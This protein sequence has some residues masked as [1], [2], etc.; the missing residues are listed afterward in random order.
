ML[1]EKTDRI[2]ELLDAWL[3]GTIDQQGTVELNEFVDRH[4]NAT[5]LL[6]E[7]DRPAREYLGVLA[8]HD[9]EKGWKTL[10]KRLFGSI[11]GGINRWRIASWKIAAGVILLIGGAIMAYLLS[12]SDQQVPVIAD[13]NQH[14]VPS[15]TEYPLLI[16]TDG[17]KIKLDSLPEIASVNDAGME[18]KA[19]KDSG[20]SYLGVKG[21]MVASGLNTLYVPY[22]KVYRI[23]LPD[24]SKVWVNGGSTIQY[25]TRF[26]GI[27]RKVSL[28]GEAYFDV[29]KGNGSFKVSASG[30]ELTVLGTRFNVNTYANEPYAAASLLEGKLR[31]KKG[32]V[33]LQ[34]LPG[35]EAKIN[36]QNDSVQI[37]NCDEAVLYWT[38]RDG[39]YHG[40]LDGYLR[41]IERQ[42]GTPLRYENVPQRYKDQII[43]TTMS[44][45]SPLT[46][47]LRVLN[48]LVSQPGNGKL[49]VEI[50]DSILVV[51]PIQ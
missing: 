18:I 46:L 37:G 45:Q 51:R 15:G 9:T 1:V 42:F 19:E 44:N 33:N 43:L 22:G 7:M 23:Y 17:T 32:T 47:W 12:K 21:D 40:S 2:V 29:A 30:M 20:L 48:N 50:K 25:P 31:I 39:A 8:V 36:R 34:L 10:K 35:K 3:T 16:L 4:P 27:D 11:Y 6:V 49:R 26:I 13:S 28:S 14:H 41:K 24:S 5:S 38:K